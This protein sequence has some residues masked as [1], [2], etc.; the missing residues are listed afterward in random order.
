M[1]DMTFREA[2]DIAE[3]QIVY[4]NIEIIRAAWQFLIDRRHIRHMDDWFQKTAA[5][6]IELKICWPPSP[7]TPHRKPTRNDFK[8]PTD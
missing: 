5:E 8:R 2:R 6:L 3:G 7:N 4:D 1:E